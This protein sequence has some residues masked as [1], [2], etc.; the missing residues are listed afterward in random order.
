MKLTI[1]IEDE[2]F[3]QL[4]LITPDKKTVPEVAAGILKAFP[5]DIREK[6][7]IITP[8]LRREIETLLAVPVPNEKEL[9]RRIATHAS[10]TI[11]NIRLKPTA[12]QME[13][14]SRLAKANHKDPE[15]VANEIFQKIA[16]AF[17][18]YV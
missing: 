3:E 6:H 14:L 17:F 15:E 10:V 4:K 13:K 9:L 2:L 18:G 5:I 8:A 16:Y 7:I 11:G 12:A 1:T